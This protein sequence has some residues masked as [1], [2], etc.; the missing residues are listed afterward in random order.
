MVRPQLSQ[1][2]LP[3]PAP[4]P[5]LQLEWLQEVAQPLWVDIPPCREWPPGLPLHLASIWLLKM[6]DR[7]WRRSSSASLV[8]SGVARGEKIPTFF[9]AIFSMCPPLKGRT[10]PEPSRKPQP[11]SHHRMS[12]LLA[13]G[14][15]EASLS[16]VS[17]ARHSL[18]GSFICV[19]NQP[20]PIS[21]HVPPSLIPLAPPSPSYHWVLPPGVPGP[22]DQWIEHSRKLKV[23]VGNHD[24]PVELGQFRGRRPSLALVPQSPAPTGGHTHFEPALALSGGAYLPITGGQLLPDILS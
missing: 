5:E 3:R 13:G 2:M 17:L 11:R 24:L 23:G 22:L 4:A 21:P 14:W 16:S 20:L 12:S 9:F 19:W 18:W 7:C 6:Y 1:E 15:S 10:Q 8:G